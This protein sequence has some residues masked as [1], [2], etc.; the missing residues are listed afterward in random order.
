[1]PAHRGVLAARNEY[2]RRL[3]LSGMQVGRS[4]GG[5]QEM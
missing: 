4:E 1:L 2:F 3:F 5:V